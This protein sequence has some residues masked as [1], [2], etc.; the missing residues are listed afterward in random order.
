LRLTFDGAN[1]VTK[2]KHTRAVLIKFFSQKLS[3][4]AEQAEVNACKIEHLIS[5]EIIEKIEKL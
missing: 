2:T 1:I 4:D 5:D 3:I